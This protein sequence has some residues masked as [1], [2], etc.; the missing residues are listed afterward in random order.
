MKNS[1]TENSA[2]FIKD[3]CIFGA[4]PTQDQI[5]I[6]EKWGVDLIINLTSDTEKKIHPYETVTKV[7]Q[8]VIPD[9]GIPDDTYKFCSLIIY[10]TNQILL[11]K[12]IYIHCK[13]GH[14]RA[15]L[16]VACI[17]CYLHKVTPER[18][19]TM[20]TGYH[21]TRQVHS[22]K[23]K[24]HAFWKRIGSPQTQEQRD[25]VEKMFP[26]YTLKQ[27]DWLSRKYDHFLKTTYL[28]KFNGLNENIEKYRDSLFKHEW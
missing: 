20:T 22:S 17:L 5:E 23:P 15:G 14:G 9:R 28:G 13:G 8:F 18:A 1:I 2:F 11:R 3:Q 19:I 21:A 7:I 27:K 24:Q 25:F 26:T 12:K 16:V 10:I 6:L 4:Y